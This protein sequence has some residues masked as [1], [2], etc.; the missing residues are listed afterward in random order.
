LRNGQGGNAGAEGRRRGRRREKMKTEGV[1]RI[2][3]R[4]RG[5]KTNVASDPPAIY[6]SRVSFFAS[7]LG[8]Y[9]RISIP[10]RGLVIK[11][12]VYV[13]HAICASLGKLYRSGFSHARSLRERRRRGWL[14][15]R[16]PYELSACRNEFSLDSIIAAR[17]NYPENEWRNDLCGR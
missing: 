16:D 2:R 6:P 12:A 8:G 10:V 13:R 11:L 15:R 17:A 4:I 3:A 9:P 14:A 5:K 1:A 7:P